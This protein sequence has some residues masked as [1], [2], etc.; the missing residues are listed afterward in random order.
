MFVVIYTPGPAW[1][2]VKTVVSVAM[3]KSPQ[4]PE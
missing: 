1:Q 3:V 4:T 2:T